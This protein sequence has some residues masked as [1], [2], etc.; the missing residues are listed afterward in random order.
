M[1]K[2]IYFLFIVAAFFYINY[3]LNPINKIKSGKY[4]LL[5]EFKDGERIV[6]ENKIVS[7]IDEEDCWSFTNGYACNCK[8]IKRN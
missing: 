1:K 8:L 6:P 2:I 4:E 3:K 5:C 7:Y